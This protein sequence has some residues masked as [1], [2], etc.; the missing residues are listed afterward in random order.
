MD[1]N[2]GE[3]LNYDVLDKDYGRAWAV[4][5]GYG[6]VSEEDYQEFLSLIDSSS[7]GAN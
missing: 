6:S 5:P 7:S 2:T 4:G 3:L 1:N